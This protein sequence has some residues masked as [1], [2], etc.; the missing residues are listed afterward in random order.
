[1]V[2]RLSSSR[3]SQY[4]KCCVYVIRGKRGLL[5]PGHKMN[6]K[7]VQGGMKHLPH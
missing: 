4:S 1:M 6:D 2:K 7:E 3:L 5:T